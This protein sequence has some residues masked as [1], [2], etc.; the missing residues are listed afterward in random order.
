MEKVQTRTLENGNENEEVH[1][2]KETRGYVW[3]PPGAPYAGCI[4]PFPPF[5]PAPLPPVGSPVP[6]VFFGGSLPGQV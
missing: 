2:E 6:P 3:S 5:Q 4:P 1:Q